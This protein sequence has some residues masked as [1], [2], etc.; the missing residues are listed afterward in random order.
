MRVYA[1]KD[2]SGVLFSGERC[3]GLGPPWG[4]GHPS[5]WYDRARPQ[6]F[7]AVAQYNPSQS[8]VGAILWRGGAPY[9]PLWRA[10]RGKGPGAMLIR[11]AVFGLSF[12]AYE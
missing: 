11:E 2:Y 7:A 3:I 5:H 8:A 9:I 4:Y 6:N 12:R 1:K 10:E